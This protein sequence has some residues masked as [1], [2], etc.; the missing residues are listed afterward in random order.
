MKNNYNK[1][2]S[3]SNRNSEADRD[4]GFISYN[5][6]HFLELHAYSFTFIYKILVKW[7]ARYGVLRS[8]DENLERIT[9]DLY[10]FVKLWF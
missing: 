3:N 5:I 2:F 6:K 4:Y 9:T 10:K 8:Y 1:R 7:E